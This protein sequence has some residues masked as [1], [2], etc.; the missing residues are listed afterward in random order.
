MSKIPL[1]IHTHYSVLQRGL[2]VLVLFPLCL[3]FSKA[4]F[5]SKG[6]LEPGDG[7]VHYTIAKYAPQYPELFLD[8]WGK[9]V[10]TLLS[11]PFAQL[12]FPGMII[13][14]V[15][16][17]AITSVLLFLWAEKRSNPFAWLS[18]LLLLSSLVY[19]DMVNAGMTEVLF[20]AILTGTLYLF[21]H[22]KYVWGSLLF[23]FSIFSRPE[24]NLILP[25]FFVFLVW[26]R[27]W[28]AI[29]FLTFG[30][31]L[32]SIVGYFRYKDLLWYFHKNPYPEVVP[33]Y[34]HGG[35]LD[36]IKAN[37]AIWGPFMTVFNAVG[38]LCILLA[39]FTQKRAKA[40]AYVLLVVLPGITVLFVHSYIWWKGIHGSLGLTRVMAT[41]AP[42]FVLL[43]LLFLN[44]VKRYASRLVPV[45]YFS[46]VL[47]LVGILLGGLL[48]SQNKDFDKI[49]VPETPSQQLLS[50]AA[51]WYLAQQNKGMIFYSDPYFAFKAHINPFDYSAAGNF[52]PLDK[53]NPALNLK[54]GTYLMWESHFAPDD[55]MIPKEKI[56]QNP[57]LDVLNIL[58]LTQPNGKPYEIVLARV[59]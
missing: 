48:Y 16:L 10:F 32:Y 2:L 53:G 56:T 9:P 33:F 28:K 44:E 51:D 34:G 46:T 42:L 12:G 41:V 35:P 36:F 45:N 57:S 13:F 37:Q 3:F 14:N 11:S 26:K 7:I 5:L 29:P 52:F 17:F 8:H 38:V 54:Q 27:Q 4:A 19:F 25:F 20:A 40:F 59:K 15:I 6:V 23:S 58:S 49:P 1:F 39:L 43:S 22:E 18:P 31:I 24:G 55:G 30:F 50:Q 21:F 47:L